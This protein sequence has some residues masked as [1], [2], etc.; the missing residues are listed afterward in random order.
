MSD[1]TYP[2]LNPESFNAAYQRLETIANKL[3]ASES[4]LDIDSLLPDVQAAM[5]AYDICKQ[6]LAAVG[7]A[8][9]EQLGDTPE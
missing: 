4:K 6:R 1:N 8:L 9:D 5:A 2:A 3:R 7:L